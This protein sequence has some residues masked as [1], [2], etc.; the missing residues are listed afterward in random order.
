MKSAIL[1]MAALAAAWSA[2]AQSNTTGTLRGQ[3]L[4]ANGDAISQARVTV[5][6]LSSG[7]TRTVETGDQGQFQ[8]AGLAAG[9]YS[10]RVEKPGFSTGEVE[11]VGVSVGGTTLQRISLAL[12]SVIQSLDVQDQPEALQTGATNGNVTFGGDR[13]EEAP[14]QGRNYLNFVLGAPGVSPS[15]GANTS[16][17]LAGMRNPANDSG[18]IFNG[19]RGRNNSISID[20]VD[21]RD[22]TTG[23]NRVAVGLEMIQQFRVSG[24]SV[25]AEFGGAAGGLVNVVTHSGENLWHGDFTFFGQN[26][27][28]N[29]RNAEVETAGRPRARKYQPGVSAGG[30]AQR[31]KT[32]FFFAA[33]QSW[34]NAEEW[35][36]APVRSAAKINQ[37]LKGKAAV[38]PGLFDSG[39]SDSE[40]AIKGTHLLSSANSLTA[41]YAFSRGRVRN[42]V[43][44]GDNFTDVSARG[45]SLLRDHSLVVGWTSAISP[46]R[47]N[48]LR[49]QWSERIGNLTPNS[50]N[51]TYMVPGVVTFGGSYQLD[52]SRTEGHVEAVESFQWQTGSHLMSAGLSFHRV[53]FDGKLAN[54]FRGI[55]IFPTLEDLL[56]GRPDVAIQAF[57]NPATQYSTIPLGLWFQDRWTVA[58]GLTMEAGLRYDRQW[59]PEQIPETKRNVAPRL[60]IAWHPGGES[61]WVFRAG[62]GLFYDRYPLAY[63]ND[64]LQKDGVHGYEVYA[65]GSAASLPLTGAH[66]IYYAAPRFLS[67]YSRKVTLGVERKIDTDT[68]L[69]VEYSNVRGI[70]LPRTRNAALTL[71]PQYALEQTATST[72]SG[73]N[74][75]LNRRLADNLTYLVTY[76][77]STTKDDASDFD[78]QPLDPGDL[79]RDW[80][81]SRQHQRHR[82]A[83]SGVWELPSGDIK[84]LDNITAAPV[85]SWGSGRPL[86]TLLTTDAFRTGAFPLSARPLAFG[87]NTQFT[88]RTVS[89]DVRLMKTIPI[90]DNRA[91]LQFGAEA[92][93]LIN[94]T[95]YLRVSPYYTNTFGTMVEAQNPR[96]VQ[97]MIQF[98]Y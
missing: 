16:R 79:R 58:R 33:E 56:A 27:L 25:S 35:S 53:T 62:A 43:Q 45:S 21:N 11:S 28:L 60:G 63:L 23:G 75:A 81:L 57:G 13:I 20:G 96:Q 26:E 91:R 3:V 92:F 1:A 6:Q 65:A 94:H 29:A 30:P 97:L 66:S 14:A 71:P 46:T 7:A 95:N 37:V 64:A 18:F 9:S 59:L 10:I 34:E 90:H 88:P 54:R 76:N 39:E 4:D 41:R 36:E 17:S 87:R 86:N 55:Y 77:L 72:Y 48:D 8:S 24:T 51:P 67:T 84:A 78:E 61:G 70:H 19:M 52:Q 50:N 82:I 69:T 89:V 83:L 15:A 85:V 49:A 47:L 68:T 73:I 42:D 2:L 98:E 22:E 74:F 38:T 44:S 31:D 93:N 80:A 5:R 32:F 40:F 12:S